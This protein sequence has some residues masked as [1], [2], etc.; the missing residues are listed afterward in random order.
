MRA[1]IVLQVPV[2]LE[3]VALDFSPEWV[4]L[5]AWQQD[6]YWD[7]MRENH[8]L[9]ASLGEDPVAFL[10]RALSKVAGSRKRSVLGSTDGWC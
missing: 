7:V 2:T 10:Q 1:L 4:E 6:L 5:A 3:D 9:V 8:T